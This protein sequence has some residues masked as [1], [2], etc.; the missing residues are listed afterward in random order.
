MLNYCKKLIQSLD[1]KNIKTTKTV[2]N[3]L[4]KSQFINR[5]ANT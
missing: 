4:K 3:T 2:E 5:I 1:F